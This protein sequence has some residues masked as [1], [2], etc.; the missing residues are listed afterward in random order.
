[1]LFVTL[2]FDS[3]VMS[4]AVT[5]QPEACNEK[6]MARA[7]R[8]RVA[9]VGD[10]LLLQS[11]KENFLLQFDNGVST[12]AATHGEEDIAPRRTTTRRAS[13]GK[14]TNGSSL[15][16]FEWAVQKVPASAID[17]SDEH[18]ESLAS[19]TNVAS[20]DAASKGGAD[21]LD[22]GVGA[23]HVGFEAK[24]GQIEE[25]SKE[26]LPWHK[27]TGGVFPS[28]L[29]SQNSGS[30][31]W[32]PMYIII[33]MVGLML[34]LF[35]AVAVS[36]RCFD[37][38]GNLPSPEAS[39][40]RSIARTPGC[41]VARTVPAYRRREEP[42]SESSPNTQQSLGMCAPGS[43]TKLPSQSAC[44]GGGI[45]IDP[46]S[47]PKLSTVASIGGVSAISPGVRRR[48]PETVSDE[49]S[50][51]GRQHSTRPCAKEPK[52]QSTFADV[53]IGGS[54]SAHGTTPLLCPMLVVPQG[55][56]FVFAVKEIISTG[57]Q[58]PISFNIVDLAGN[59]LCH[60]I[61]SEQTS[62]RCGIYLEFLDK[63]PLAH[64]NTAPVHERQGGMPDICRPGSGNDVFCSLVRCPGGSMTKYVLRNKLGE[65]LVTFTGNFREKAIN[66]IAPSGMNLCYTRRCTLNVDNAP[67]GPYYEVRVRP[68]FDAGLLLCGL[69]AID[70]VEGSAFLG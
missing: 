29:Q 15:M 52:P 45:A 66:G 24:S 38:L 53:N 9:P 41:V 60:A 33:V 67:Q 2:I 4:T 44:F 58:K 18:T 65:C 37:L 64:V 5:S 11:K 50:Q 36:G 20:V 51:L 70:K 35:V 43:L 42:T 31:N 57:R 10:H 32:L 48:S 69:L 40:Q 55:M 26:V 6:T 16:E 47:D 21:L 63:E 39:T 30:H 34:P 49:R 25:N 17:E 3:L 62:E 59:P 56:E 61:V 22:D 54:G 28:L 8:Q 14:R 7:T 46:D 12:G 68:S 23:G 13:N 19:A 1:M 27:S